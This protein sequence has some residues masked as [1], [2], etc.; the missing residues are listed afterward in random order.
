MA[1]RTHDLEQN[2][3]IPRVS[4]SGQIDRCC[5]EIF[6]TPAS[7][8]KR[9]V[10]LVGQKKAVAIVVRNVKHVAQEDL[11]SNIQVLSV[12]PASGAAA[13]VMDTRTLDFLNLIQPPSPITPAPGCSPAWTHV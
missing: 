3:W 6:S 8:G 13:P 2:G 4:R 9:L 11:K 12:A 7:R 1:A 10:V 5:S